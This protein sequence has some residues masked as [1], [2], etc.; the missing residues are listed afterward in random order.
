MKEFLSAIGGLIT[1]AG[2]FPVWGIPLD[3]GGWTFPQGS[4]GG[5][6]PCQ[7][8]EQ[9][10]R[11]TGIG[12]RVPESVV[13]LDVDH[14]DGK[15]GGDTLAALEAELGPLP[16]PRFKVTARDPAEPGGRLMYN[17][18]GAWADGG[19]L[20]VTSL[21]GH[22][23]VVSKWHKFSWATGHTH[24]KTN[25]MV[26]V[27]V[28][29]SEGAAWEDFTD[30]A[31]PEPDDLEPLPLNWEERLTREPQV[32]GDGTAG[33]PAHD[34]G[35]DICPAVLTWFKRVEHQDY[36]FE[37][38]K[39]GRPIL[40]P[41]GHTAG[42]GEVRGER[43]WNAVVY[44]KSMAAKGHNVGAVISATRAAYPA[45]DETVA[46]R[47]DAAK[48][49]DGD[50]PACCKAAAVSIETAPVAPGIVA[51]VQS[52]Q[53]PAVS[54]SG[55]KLISG[56]DIKPKRVVW[57]WS[58]HDRGGDLE[59]SNYIPDYS[60]SIL[61]GMPGTGKTQ[62]AYSLAGKLSRG[63]IGNGKDHTLIIGTED[64][65]ESIA[66]PRL[67][68]AGVDPA[69]YTVVQETAGDD[70]IVMSVNEEG[71]RQVIRDL[72]VGLVVLDPLITVLSGDSDENSYKDIN[73]ELQRLKRMAQ[74][75]KCVV[76][77]ITHFKKGDGGALD[78][79]LGSRAF[80]SVPRSL[81]I[82]MEDDEGQMFLSAAKSSSGKQPMGKAYEI[83]EMGWQDGSES[84]TAPY[85]RELGPY[86]VL[87]QMKLEADEVDLAGEFVRELL[88]EWNGWK[89]K[90]STVKK[91]GK[92]AGFSERTIQRV[93][94]DGKSPKIETHREGFPST[95]YWF[96][97]REDDFSSRAKNPG[98]T[99][100]DIQ[101]AVEEFER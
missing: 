61:A 53:E 1:K 87:A 24:V 78:K 86:E 39:H 94:S 34:N 15:R 75:E 58:E 42:F 51:P 73:V 31:L 60:L 72:G 65:L 21:P 27:Y 46:K 59:P 23:D 93:L 2:Y 71:I 82:A 81:L 101:A 18:E 33:I 62:W 67:R 13:L 80:T 28:Q 89:V 77:G 40:R 43:E 99:E 83:A 38:D 95:V 14:Y 64:D 10:P 92:A 90:S 35:R 69:K 50:D 8:I 29:V 91:L 52:R 85:I 9:D 66:A 45:F 63:E 100:E 56:I 84:I 79:V 48:G 68:A 49:K 12:F 6:H 17:V 4:T 19:D 11:A 26:R 22:I 7:V 57:F 70:Q 32:L 5:Y 97:P 98:V 74:Q 41:V 37:A 36:E 88:R 96:L 44:L 30:A 76:V 3:G 55:L 47:W 16:Y 54:K 20:P 25:T